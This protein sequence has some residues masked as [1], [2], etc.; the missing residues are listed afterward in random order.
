MSNMSISN[1]LATNGV[2]SKCRIADL[3]LLCFYE[4]V[5]SKYSAIA[6][7][8]PVATLFN[9][10]TYIKPHKKVAQLLL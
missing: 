1:R 2:L 10:V 7:K 4:A 6:G 3:L 9:A 5:M 8:P